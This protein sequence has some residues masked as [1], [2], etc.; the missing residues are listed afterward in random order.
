MQKN[1]VNYY[2][3]YFLLDFTPFEVVSGLA[4]GF[5]HFTQNLLRMSE[6]FGKLWYTSKCAPYLELLNVFFSTIR[7]M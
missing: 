5:Q 4:L 2:S 1:S 3:A 6:N 7:L